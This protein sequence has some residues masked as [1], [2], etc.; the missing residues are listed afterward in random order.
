M[1]HLDV[2]LVLETAKKSWRAFLS[3]AGGSNNY[4]RVSRKSP[5]L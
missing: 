4:Q 3:V 1:T 5:G 2:D